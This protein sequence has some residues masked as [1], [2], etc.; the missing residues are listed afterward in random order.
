MIGATIDGRILCVV[1]TRR[2]EQVRVVTARDADTAQRRRYRRG[3]KEHHDRSDTTT[4]A[5]DQVARSA[6]ENTDPRCQRDSALRDRTG[7]AAIL[8]YPCDGTGVV[9]TP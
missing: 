4:S 1:Y 2:D 6:Y 3:R 9:R 7:R 5:D 8:G